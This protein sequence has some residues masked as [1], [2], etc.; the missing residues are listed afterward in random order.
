MTV[1]LHDASSDQFR[2]TSELAQLAAGRLALSLGVPVWN[3]RVMLIDALIAQLISVAPV[4]TV[5]YMRA[6]LNEIAE[7]DEEREA[8]FRANGADFLIAIGEKFEDLARLT[9]DEIDRNG[10]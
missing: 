1:D 7:L 10:A 2:A 6:R 3:A 4:A 8:F 5:D 9:S